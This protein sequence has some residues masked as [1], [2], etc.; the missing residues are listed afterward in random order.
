MVAAA[1]A[2]LLAASLA[3]AASAAA[4]RAESPHMSVPAAA[5]TVTTLSIFEPDHLL[6]SRGNL[7]WTY[8][9]GSTGGQHH[10]RLYS[11]SKAGPAGTAFLRYQESGTDLIYFRALA[12]A[13]I[14]TQWYAYFVVDNASTHTSVIKRVNLAGGSAVTIV[15]SPRFIGSR[16]LVT[17][18]RFLFWADEG[19]LRRSTMGGAGRTTLATGASFGSIDLDLTNVYFSFGSS[20]WS[21]PKSQSSLEREVTG[22]SAITSLDVHNTVLTS[23]YWS[24]RNGSVRG[25]N[26]L[27]ERVTY[28][29]P[30]TAGRR[31]TSVSASGSRVAWTD[32]AAGTKDCRTRRRIGNDTIS[33]PVGNSAKNVQLDDTATFWGDGAGLR[34]FAG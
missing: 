24:E 26:F 7:Y 19:G 30:S 29:Q 11:M 9:V 22:T 2:T 28:Q 6:Q 8:N 4:S 13:K 5:P 23:L 34:K 15:A 1:C 10:A 16:G 17:D 33:V 20:V 12:Y 27:S 21:T 32:C 14:G 3:T 25:R 18:G 31:A